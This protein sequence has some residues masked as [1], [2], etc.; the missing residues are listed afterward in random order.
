MHIV[1]VIILQR[2]YDTY[3]RTYSAYYITHFCLR[4]NKPRTY[5][6]LVLNL[7]DRKVGQVVE[8]RFPLV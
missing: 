7:H 1:C 4:N 6:L 2:P 5:L 8:R 3:V